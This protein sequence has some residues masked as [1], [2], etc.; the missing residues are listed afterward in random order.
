MEAGLPH[1]RRRAEGATMPLGLLIA[2][3]IAE[4][5][6]VPL[7]FFVSGVVLLLLTLISALLIL[8]QKADKAREETS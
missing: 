4:N 2:G 6:G 3:S 5:K 8:P 7:W 1:H